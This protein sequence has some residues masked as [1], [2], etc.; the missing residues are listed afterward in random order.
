MQD[1][2]TS[3]R[4]VD[5]SRRRLA[6]I[7]GGGAVLATLPL[8]A[9]A[10]SRT[11]APKGAGPNTAA[12]NLGNEARSCKATKA[13]SRAVL[14]GT[15][16]AI[17]QAYRNTASGAPAAA[18]YRNVA[19]SLRMFFDHLDELGVSE[20]IETHVKSQTRSPLDSKTIAKIRRRLA[21]TGMPGTEVF[22][23]QLEGG[24]QSPRD[25]AVFDQRGLR[26]LY[27]G[28]IQGFAEVAGDI[29]RTSGPKARPSVG[30]SVRPVIWGCFFAESLLSLV[31][32]GS[33]GAL[34]AE[35]AFC[36]SGWG[37]CV[38]AIVGAAAVLADFYNNVNPCL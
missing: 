17:I 21:G 37:T 16:A 13:P 35:I 18:D 36:S 11:A 3:K 8:K 34:A 15:Y 6:I 26:G 12:P 30:L 1:N 25:L 29:E 28:V 23:K 7:L 24:R 9:T 27:D 10:P 33:M 4:E 32:A 2:R 19:T 31:N 38:C 22:M 20:A 5:L 14:K